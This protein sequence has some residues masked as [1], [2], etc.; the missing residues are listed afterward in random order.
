MSENTK[1][2]SF[3]RPCFGIEEGGEV[4]GM[5][6]WF[7]DRNGEG[8]NASRLGAPLLGGNR[9]LNSVGVAER[10][11][12]FGCI[13]RIIFDQVPYT[14]SFVYYR[15]S[16]YESVGIFYVIQI[17]TAA[18]ANRF[19]GHGREWYRLVRERVQFNITISYTCFI[20]GDHEKHYYNTYNRYFHR[21]NIIRCFATIFGR[22]LARRIR[23]LLL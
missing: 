14:L 4:G 19:L 18:I 13:A 5:S 11:A 1:K 23:L 20:A 6:F 2:I 9:N 10:S 21:N 12:L 16:V 3:R 15:D 17:R 22:F 7:K 8:R